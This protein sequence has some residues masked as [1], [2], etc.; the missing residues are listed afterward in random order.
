MDTAPV[1]LWLRGGGPD[2]PPAE[3]LLGVPLLRAPGQVGLFKLVT[4]S[5]WT[6]LTW[7][8]VVN[9]IEA[10]DESAIVSLATSGPC[11]RTTITYDPSLPRLRARA[12][13][14]E[15]GGRGAEAVES[16]PGL[17]VVAWGTDVSVAQ[18]REALDATTDGMRGWSVVEWWEPSE[19]TPEALSGYLE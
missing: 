19:R 10:D 18:I 14:H 3:C 1:E 2:A 4:S 5:V 17:F 9:V 7:G 12:I 8:D 11:T 13:A 16:L 15:W 6:P